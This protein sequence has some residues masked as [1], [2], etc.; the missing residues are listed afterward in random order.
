M[1]IE[2][3]EARTR[4]YRSGDV[5]FFEG[6]AAYEAYIVR[7]G[8]VE[9]SI[10]RGRTRKVL[11]TIG[12][13]QMFGEMAIIAEMRRS[14]TVT[15]LED[16]ELVVVDRNLIEPK[17]RQMDPYLKYLMESLID[18]LFRTSRWSQSGSPRVLE[19]LKEADAA[20]AGSSGEDEDTQGGGS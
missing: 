16:T 7:T 5:I 10:G 17:I 13:N 3:K 15:C 2:Y 1:S 20:A 19:I 9:V 11:D 6:D 12:P 18:R 4:N 8:R 14:A